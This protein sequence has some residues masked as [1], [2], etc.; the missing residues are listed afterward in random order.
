MNRIIHRLLLPALLLVAPAFSAHAQALKPFT[1]Q[2]STS[3]QRLSATASMS[4]KPQGNGRWAYAL[5]V[6]SPVGRMSQATVFSDRGGSF[7]LLSGADQANYLGQ[8]K[9]VT[10]RYSGGQAK[11]GGDVKPSRAGPVPMRAGDLDALLVNLAL[12]RDVAAGRTVMSYRVLENGKARTLNYRVH[13]RGKQTINGKQVDAVQL[14]QAAGNKQTVVWAAAGIPA[15]LRITQF[16]DGKETFR[17]Q[18][19]SWK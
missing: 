18:M 16:E 7:Q 6:S 13:K 19:T 9:S 4:L 8:S 3:Y 10:A 5:G 15:P 12:A 17:L 11:W 1:A 2:Y 14:V